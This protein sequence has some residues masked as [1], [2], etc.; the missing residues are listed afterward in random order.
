MPAFIRL[1]ML[2]VKVGGSRFPGT[3]AEFHELLVLFQSEGFARE[4]RAGDA[5]DSGTESPEKRVHRPITFS[6]WIESDETDTH[7]L[8]VFF[9][10]VIVTSFITSLTCKREFHVDFRCRRDP[11]GGEFR[12]LELVLESHLQATDHFRAI[13]RPG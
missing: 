10:Q 2:S 8:E 7:G 1:N 3:F 9:N 11:V 13:R 12:G 6:G 5:L 4:V